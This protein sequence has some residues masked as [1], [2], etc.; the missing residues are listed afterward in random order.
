[1]KH[2]VIARCK[3]NIIFRRRQA[4]REEGPRLFSKSLKVFHSLLYYWRRLLF[5]VQ[6]S[7]PQWLKGSFY[8]VGPG[9]IQVGPLSFIQWDATDDHD[10]CLS[11]RGLL[12]PAPLRHALRHA[13]VHHRA[14]RGEGQHLQGSQ[15]DKDMIL[16]SFS[17]FYSKNDPSFGFPCSQRIT[18]SE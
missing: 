6:G 10:R 7:V 16:S 5:H 1:M 2:V 14:Q 18:K 17:I 11:G 13:Q 8:R 12:L 15:P 3:G 4:S 9:I